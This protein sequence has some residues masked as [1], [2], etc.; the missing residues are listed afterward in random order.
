M[1][2]FAFIPFIGISIVFVPIALYLMLSGQVAK[3][4]MFFIYF[5]LLSGIVE[6]LVKPKIVGDRVK[7]HVLLV[8]ISIFGGIAT[9]G[10]LG[11][12]LGPLVAI[13]FLTLA[14]IYLSTVGED[15]K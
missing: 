7:M 12:L 14:D 9:F 10:I 2:I 13:A 4:I 6:Y 15:W 3:G 1:A 5:S 11:I 8:F